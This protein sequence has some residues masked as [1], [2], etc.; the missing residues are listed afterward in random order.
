MFD[1]LIPNQTIQIVLDRFQRVWDD[2]YS[3][4]NR[5]RKRGRDRG[6]SEEE[7][8]PSVKD[9]K[10]EAVGA[11]R[12]VEDAEDNRELQ[13]GAFNPWH[14]AIIRSAWFFGYEGSLT[15]P[16]CTEFV[17]WR[18]IDVPALISKDQLGQMQT[19]LFGHIDSKCKETSVHYNGSVAR[20]IQSSLGREVHKCMCRDYLGNGHRK[21]YTPT[22]A[23]T[24]NRGKYAAMTAARA[25][26]AR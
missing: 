12:T 21:W 23:K 18:I 17:E 3:A 26:Q 13:A 2:D 19:L 25:G 8:G 4:C 20:P 22:R 7:D 6:L 14:P 5:L 10:A 11:D 9:E 16:P 15:E 1:S 24:I